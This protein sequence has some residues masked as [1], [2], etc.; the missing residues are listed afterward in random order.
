MAVLIYID[1]NQQVPFS[2][3]FLHC[4]Q[5]YLCRV[6]IWWLY[7]CINFITCVYVHIP[8][9]SYE[10]FSPNKTRNYRLYKMSQGKTNWMLHSLILY[11]YRE[12]HFFDFT[13]KFGRYLNSFVFADRI[14]RAKPRGHNCKFNEKRAKTRDFVKSH[15][16]W[17]TRWKFQIVNAFSTNIIY[18]LENCELGYI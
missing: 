6:S 13:R 1:V 12:K 18:F 9:S 15:F 3:S 4:N 10:I 14:G 8:F 7:G 16:L 11:K 2:I 17:G 5:V